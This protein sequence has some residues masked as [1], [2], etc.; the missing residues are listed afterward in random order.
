MP[1]CL[2]EEAYAALMTVDPFEKI[3][4]VEELQR[5]HARGDLICQPDFITCRTEVPGRPAFP[6]LVHPREVPRRGLGSVAGQIAFFHALAHIEFNAI[7]LGIDAVYRFAP[8]MPEEYVGDWLSVAADEARHFQMLNQHLVS[9]GSY[10][11]ASC[12]H[13][14]LWEMAVRTDFDVM[15]RMALVP[16]VLEARGLDVAPGMI[17]RLRH[18]GD[19]LGADII[20]TILEEEV[21][22]VAIGNRWFLHQCEQRALD[23]QPTF[24]E[25]LR[26]HTRGFLS[27][28]FNDKYRKQAGFS[29]RELQDLREMEAQ[30]ASELR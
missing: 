23:P 5:M 20:S 2:Q 18:L 27:G 22:H 4:A 9:L 16:R 15:V 28:P 19:H 3:L 24:R 8:Q 7:N 21:G 6:Q 14:N 11:G 13:N 10:Y 1:F 25:L 29:D 17:D 12:A 26:Q 30:F